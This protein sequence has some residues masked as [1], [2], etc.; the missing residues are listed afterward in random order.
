MQSQLAENS[1]PLFKKSKRETE[2]NFKP[3]GN[4]NQFNFNVDILDDIQES[5]NHVKNNDTEL[6]HSS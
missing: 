6:V 4:K 5:I 1:R 3:I 2:C